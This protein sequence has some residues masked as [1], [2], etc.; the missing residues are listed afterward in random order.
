MR[1]CSLVGHRGPAAP[2]L[3]LVML[4]A[5]CGGA[6]GGQ[7]T[8]PAEPADEVS[9]SGSVVSGDVTVFAAASLTEAFTVLGD[10]FTAGHPETTVTFSFGPSSGLAQQIISGA[11]AD[12]FAAAS[13]A[14]MQI[15]VDVGD[16]TDVPDRFASNSLQ[17]AVP[18]GNPGGVAG[19][20]DFTDPD[21]TIALCAVEVPC[22]AAAEQVFA[23]A[24]LTAAP[25]TLETDV[26]AALS[27]VQLGEVDA[28]LVYRTDVTAAGG[29]VEGIELPEGSA[30]VNDYSIAV[31]TES[32][33]SDAAR[34]FVDY[35]Q[36]PEG[37]QILANAGFTTP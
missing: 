1:Y 12:V 32:P 6:R 11:P 4:L 26:K 21:L 37:Q 24:G 27:K 17:I 14:T 35:V 23:A 22:G 15:V 16:V 10:A 19:L 31:L 18:P 25:D 28:A 2:V 33:N 8:V 29:G 13:P 36:S 3:I 30:A 20:A 9:V 34:A 5:A 7:A